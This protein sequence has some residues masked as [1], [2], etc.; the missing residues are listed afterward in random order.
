MIIDGRK[1]SQQI[2]K[3]LQTEVAKLPARPIFCDIL[4]GD[5]P[6]SAQYVRMKGKQA[7]SIGMKFRQA[8]YPATINTE[9]LI[10]EIQKIN[11]TPDL[12]GLIVQLPLPKHL[13]KT[14]VLNAIASDIDVDCTGAV[15]SEKFYAGK[16][17]LVFPT[18]AAVMALLD[19]LNLDLGKKKFAVVGQ[20]ELVGKPVSFLLKQRNYQ[21][22]VADIKTKN[23]ASIIK[24]A[25][26][27]ISAVGKPKLITGE[28]VKAGSII[29]DAGTSESKCG[30]VGDVDFESVKN[31]ANY[32]S[33]VPG[34]VGPM[35]VAML[36]KNVLSVAQ[37]N[38]HLYDS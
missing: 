9:Q 14:A 26:V 16:G 2:L 22:R 35:T 33:P 23:T 20:G 32:L 5:D 3:Q 25:D 30:I 8:E 19:S 17:D 1:I 4:V 34:G 15:N 37:K 18:A 13:D 11:Q 38:R 31:I 24:N 36:L 27:V 28:M 29:I 7:E 6:V 21:L 10:Q 12:C